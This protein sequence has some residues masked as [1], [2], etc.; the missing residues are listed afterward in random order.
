ML[1]KDK[2][3]ALSRLSMSLANLDEPQQAMALSIY[4]YA[5][6]V[7]RLHYLP[8]VAAR[9]ECKIVPAEKLNPE[10]KMAYLRRE[11]VPKRKCS[12]LFG[13]ETHNFWPIR[14]DTGLMF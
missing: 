4:I 12:L 6:M 11:N 14:A 5:D 13:S 7:S 2:K 10:T 1:K 3:W 8:S 9:L